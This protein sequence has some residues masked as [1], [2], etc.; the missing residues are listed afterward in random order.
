[1]WVGHLRCRLHTAF[2]NVWNG[3]WL[4][5]VQTF[6]SKTVFCT[7]MVGKGLCLRHTSGLCVCVCLSKFLILVFYLIWLFSYSEVLLKLENILNT[8]LYNRFLQFYLNKD[9]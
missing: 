8:A 9:T 1:M 4:F 7:N 6:E 5:S 3:G 2:Q